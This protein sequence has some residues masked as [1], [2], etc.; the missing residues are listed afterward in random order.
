MCNYC[1]SRLGRDGRQRSNNERRVI[2]CVTSFFLYVGGKLDRRHRAA[3]STYRSGPSYNGE[4]VE[5]VNCCSWQ[6]C[7][8]AAAALLT[9]WRRWDSLLIHRYV[10]LL[11]ASTTC[12]VFFFCFLL[13]QPLLLPMSYSSFQTVALSESQFRIFLHRHV[14][15]PPTLAPYYAGGGCFLVAINLF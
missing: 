1:G 8:V 7:W 12:Y 3:G 6:G 15:L 5:S 11:P 14:P 13:N 9:F 4:V 10:S 2:A